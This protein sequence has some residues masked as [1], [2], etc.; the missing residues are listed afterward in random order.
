M[1]NTWRIPDKYSP[2]SGY[3]LKPKICCLIL[4]KIPFEVLSCW[5]LTIILKLIGTQR[6]ENVTSVKARPPFTYNV[7]QL[8]QTEPGLIFMKYKFNL[9]LSDQMG[10]SSAH[11]QQRSSNPE[12]KLSLPSADRFPA[13]VQD[14]PMEPTE[15]PA[16]RDLHPHGS[17]CSITFHFELCRC[18]WT[19]SDFCNPGNGSHPASLSILMINNRD[20]NLL[21][22]RKVSNILNYSSI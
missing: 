5:W 21:L 4:S 16:K 7:K 10:T 18:I 17:G 9:S 2:G 22:V 20:Q 3:F 14:V 19:R 6:D 1:Q 15:L 8:L 12:P 11:A 13:E